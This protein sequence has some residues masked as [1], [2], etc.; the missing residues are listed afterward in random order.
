MAAA[1]AGALNLDIFGGDAIITPEGRI[2]L[3]DINSWPSFAR[4]RTEAAVQIAWQL[5]ARLRR[6]AETAGRES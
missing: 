5:R 3:I 6:R 1:G 4:V 2:Y